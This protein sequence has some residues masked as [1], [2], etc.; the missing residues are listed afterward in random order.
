VNG[1][2]LPP[3]VL[4]ALAPVALVACA[5][6]L[7]ITDIHDDPTDAGSA[8]DAGERDATS[9]SDATSADAGRDAGPDAG[10][11]ATA[12]PADSGPDVNA[13]NPARGCPGADGGPTRFKSDSTTLPSKFAINQTYVYVADPLANGYVF[14]CSIEGCD[15]GAYSVV[16]GAGGG[17]AAN[18]R[19]IFW[20]NTN[21]LET[22]NIG[23]LD[24]N[25]I[26]GVNF[27][28]G[29]AVVAAGNEAYGLDNL[30]VARLDD[31]PGDLDASAGRVQ[32][33]LGTYG[34]L[35][36]SEALVAFTMVD[37]AGTT[38]IFACPV[39]GC[40][41]AVAPL[42]QVAPYPNSV[43]P[44]TLAVDDSNVYFT[45]PVAQIIGSCK[46][47]GCDGGPTAVASAI[48]ASS[49]AVDATGIYWGSAQPGA[50]VIQK[51]PSD[52]GHPVTVSSSPGEPY[53][54]T[55]NAACVYW[56]TVGN[57]GANI[58]GALFAA[59]QP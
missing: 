11:D 58:P 52:G 41:D 7:G 59:P 8:G 51:A 15:G 2:R 57:R 29:S 39:T 26:T 38:G 49:L 5:Q 27:G 9:P 4:A 50:Y 25:W 48:V 44:V 1:R 37:D 12:P 30:G 28:S 34:A 3:V 17:I 24:G 23:D 22:L 33:Q 20:L 43:P 21:G 55:A 46:V 13:A 6:V 14:R 19:H 16:Q 31:A 18:D 47:A 40:P 32:N 54:V 36:A 56:T 45:D 35:A 10:P 53:Y 42:A